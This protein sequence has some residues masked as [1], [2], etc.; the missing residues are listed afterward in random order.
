MGPLVAAGPLAGALIGG[1]TGGVAGVLTDYG[2]S[3]DCSLYYEDKIKEGKTL[4][5]LKADEERIGQLTEVLRN[6]GV[7]DI[8]THDNQR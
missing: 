2:I 8:E 3:E 4:V 1:V 6:K 5:L 7:K